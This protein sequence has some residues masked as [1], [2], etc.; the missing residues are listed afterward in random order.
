MTL[1][2]LGLVLLLALSATAG[3]RT[4]LLVRAASWV[5]LVLGLLLATITVP[6]ALDLLGP[7]TPGAR[8][9][10]SVSAFVVTLGVLSGLANL[11]GARLRAAAASS[12]LSIV[13]QVGGVLAGL[14]G[15][16]VTVWFLAPLA[17]AVPGEIARQVRGSALIGAVQQFAPPAPNPLASLRGLLGQTRFPEVFADLAPAP[18]TAPAPPEVPVPD[19]VVERA[20]PSTVK[21][22]TEG[23]G[24]AFAGSGWTVEAGLVMTNAHVVAG[25]D[26]VRVLR[27]DGT[28][29]DAEVV[30]F[31]PERDLALL[32]VPGLDR[33][34]L[35]LAEPT[36]GEGAV[37]MG[38]PGGVDDLRLSPTTIGQPID[39]VGRDIY[40]QGRTQRRIVVLAAEL[41]QGSSGSPVVDASGGVVGVVFA[42]SP[43][44]PGTAYALAP[45]EVET[46]LAATRR[47]G[48]VGRC[49]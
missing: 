46:V 27:T 12:G 2:D 47:P 26:R 5:G 4:G 19:L 13:D 23:C 28:R 49:Q 20:A 11:V 24:L 8:A 39:A 15:V 21:V 36:A 14:V 32:A 33:P 10:V 41:E 31:D 3:W 48:S 16:A 1:L 17:G 44:A 43:D 45:R 42:V 40:G 30:T 22:E 34:P 38:H 25:A 18:A 7:A 35:S 29:L 9:I 37:T 6:E